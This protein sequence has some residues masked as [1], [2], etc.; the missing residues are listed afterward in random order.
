MPDDKL[1]V[2]E[3]LRG[4]DGHLRALRAYVLRAKRV[5]SQHPDGGGV[6]ALSARLLLASLEC[7]PGAGNGRASHRED[8][9]THDP[10]GA[11][12]V[13][14]AEVELVQPAVE[15][16]VLDPNCSHQRVRRRGVYVWGLGVGGA[17]AYGAR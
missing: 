7:N 8:A 4:A 6:R 14:G 3:E 10:E 12:D 17:S 9:V 2:V 11:V 1:F 5:R 13:V 16:K 15:A